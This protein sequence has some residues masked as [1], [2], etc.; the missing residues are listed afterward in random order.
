[1][2]NWPA[3]KF[4]DGL[5]G[6]DVHAAALRSQPVTSAA[7]REIIARII[8]AAVSPDFR[9]GSRP[10]RACTEVAARGRADP[11]GGTALS[12]DRLDVGTRFGGASAQDV[13]APTS[14]ES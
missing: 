7:D 1:M 8:T 9:L 14:L 13:D 10:G 6:V 4:A 12:A 5:V 11:Q 3:A 2:P